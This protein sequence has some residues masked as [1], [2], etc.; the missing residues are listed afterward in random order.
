MK[1]YLY[2]SLL[3]EAL[4]ASMLPTEEFGIYMATGTVKQPH[5][6]AMFLQIR[7]DFKSED[8]KLIE[9]ESR[10]IPHL[11]GKPKNSI[12][13]SIYR[14]LEHVPVD[15][16]ES[17]WLV[18]AHGKCL[19]IKASFEMPKDSQGKLHLY[20]EICPVTPLIASSLDPLEFTTFIT[21]PANAIHVPK[22]I[23]VELALNGLADD[24]LGGSADNL[25]YNNIDH[26]RNCLKELNSKQTKTVDRV[27]QQEILYRC[28]KSGSG[29][30]IGDQQ[31]V[32]YFPYPSKEELEGK[33][34]VW[35]RCA[36]GS[37]L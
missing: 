34:H 2:L 33:Y 22:I 15:A 7:R 30:F 31:K 19:E 18:T 6:Q 27:A 21:N 5:G 25:P 35:W 20:R 37:K 1:P 17:L 13:L 11:D 16:I 8:F 36:G 14:V 23:F 26:I 29:F 12:Y 24:P 4:I 28:V 9:A 32:I 3:P 10:C